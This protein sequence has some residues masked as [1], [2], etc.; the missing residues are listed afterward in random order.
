MNFASLSVAK[1]LII[2]FSL[3]GL[4]IIISGGI[5]IML[6]ARI[7][8]A[9]AVSDAAERQASSINATLAIAAKMQTAIRGL[10]VTGSSEYS[11]NYETFGASFDQLLQEAV[12]NAAGQQELLT[13]LD[14]IANA[15]TEWRDGPVASQLKL[16][17]HP[18]TVNEA[19]AIE[20]TGA[21]ETLTE[22]LEAA[23]KELA[24]AI[25][26][27]SAAANA[28]ISA[29]LDWTLRTVI[30]S[31]V[32]ML[33]AAI[34]FFFI[35]SR[36][37]G[38]PIRVITGTMK[39]LA[40]GNT[41][42]DIPYAE[43]ADEVGNMAGAVAVFADNMRKSERLQA[44]AAQ[45]QQAREK[46][47]AQMTELAHGFDQEVEAILQALVKSAEDLDQTAE[48]LTK[49][50]TESLDQVQ[51]VAAAATE[52]SSNVQTVAAATEELSSSI[53]EIS[54][55]VASQ[56][57]IAAT[58]T[59]SID[60][61]TQR[62][63]LLTEASTKIGDV[64]RLITEISNQ[65]NLLALNATI[66]AARAGEAGKG[67]AVVA[68][69]VKSLANQTARATEDIAVQVQSI[70]TSTQSTADSIRSVGDQI[71]QMKDISSGVAAAVEEQNAA[72]KEIARNIQE[73][74]AGNQEVS[75]KIVFVA[76]AAGQTQNATA[77]VL[78]AARQLGQNTAQI[79]S[80]IERFIHDVRA[81]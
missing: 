4:I 50:S 68:N 24:D 32:V 26:R 77:T 64:V 69:E 19:R 22:K 71:R 40:A 21:G 39:E 9:N 81:L 41:A 60:D 15:V 5:S 49:L 12:A 34:F 47:A 55:Q 18:S 57:Q 80:T 63:T 66:E 36:Q 42:V 3:L 13:P 53:M 45:Q 37:I 6:T 28:E 58:S 44:E 1:K 10:L 79:R 35:L 7:E 25:A 29:A 52:A 27:N 74:S 73:A 16:M 23:G 2:A 43:R 70:Q 59:E 67:F 33:V 65:T 48:S 31:A 78:S 54:R 38:A 62:V 72:T 46:R 30:V 20:V 61:T 51:K 11:R 75:E 76:E 8:R 56:A 17:R 14:A